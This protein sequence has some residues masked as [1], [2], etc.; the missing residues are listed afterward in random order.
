ME[1]LQVFRFALISWADAPPRPI[2]F[3]S[4]QVAPI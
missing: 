3:Q 2:Y 1:V 4:I